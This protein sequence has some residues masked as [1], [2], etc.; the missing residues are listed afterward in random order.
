[1]TEIRPTA[2]RPTE[3][4]WLTYGDAAQ[5]FGISSEALRSLARRQRW[6]RRS[7]NAVGGQSWV[8][9]PADRLPTAGR[10]DSDQRLE[11]DPNQLQ[12]PDRSAPTAGREGGD[13]RSE[14][15]PDCAT[16]RREDRRSDELLT[17]VREMAEI[18]IGPVREQIGDLKTQLMVEREPAD[19]A[20]RRAETAERHIDEMRAALDAKDEDH[21]QMTTLFVDERAEHRRVVALLTERIPARRRWW[22]WRRR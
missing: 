17:A 13:H 8:F 3:G 9:V 20:E 22:V 21:R 1:M 12:P 16:D 5:L 7:P 6:D 15:D 2:D 4:Q 18:L 14:I 11:T 19:R 10:T